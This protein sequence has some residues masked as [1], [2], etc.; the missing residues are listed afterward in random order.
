MQRQRLQQA[1]APLGTARKRRCVDEKS[2]F[3]TSHL[4]C[5]QRQRSL[6]S[7]RLNP[8]Q[9]PRHTTLLG[10]PQRHFRCGRDV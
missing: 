2:S 10:A 3:F 5:W 8:C 1:A 6:Q 7:Q 9:A 4:Q